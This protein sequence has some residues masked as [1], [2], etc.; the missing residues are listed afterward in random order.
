MAAGEITCTFDPGVMLK[1][2]SPS[3]A[4]F[5]LRAAVAVPRWLFR[6]IVDRIRRLR[7]PEA[8]PT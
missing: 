4:F 8:V 6:T 1:L 7:P 3:Q 2:I 5:T